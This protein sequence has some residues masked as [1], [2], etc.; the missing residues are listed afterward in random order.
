MHDA[1]FSHSPAGM[2]RDAP[3]VPTCREEGKSAARLA[4]TV[5]KSRPAT[6]RRSRTGL[7]PNPIGGTAMEMPDT[8]AG[9]NPIA[10]RAGMFMG[11]GALVALVSLFL[12]WIT[13]TLDLSEIGGAAIPPETHNG[14][15]TND[16]KITLVLAVL[17]VVFAFLIYSRAKKVFAVLGIITALLLVA[18]SLLEITY[19]KAANRKELEQQ[20]TTRLGESGADTAQ[21]IAEKLEVNV[22]PGPYV[23]LGGG[24]IALIGGIMGASLKKNETWTAAAPAAPEAAAPPP[25]MSPPVAY[26]PPAAP[27]PPPAYTPP[28]AA[29]PAPVYTPPPVS[30]PPA[31][32]PPPVSPPPAYTPP[33]SSPPPPA[34]SPMSDPAPAET[35]ER[36]AH[37]V[38][39]MAQNIP[40]AT[41]PA[42]QV[43]END[44]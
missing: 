7:A 14:L 20:L 19:S 26:T 17:I 1:G 23:A 37:Q 43:D 40:P 27:S 35:P 8:T 28:P 39:P 21:T 34:Y 15:S 24:L 38:P 22:G 11:F 32:T 42:P 31:Y 16:G 29:P 2:R 3:R 25:P 33:P 13:A 18:A 12:N 9:A 10:R 41:P 4:R 5:A 30:P 6:T 36:P 44:I